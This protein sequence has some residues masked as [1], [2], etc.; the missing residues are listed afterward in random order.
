MEYLSELNRGI[1]DQELR[2]VKEALSFNVC[3][4][5]ELEKIE[6]LT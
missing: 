4:N 5:L 2:D 3:E 1:A 6:Q